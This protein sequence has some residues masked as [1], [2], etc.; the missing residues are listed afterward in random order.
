MKNQSNTV[1]GTESLMEHKQ[2]IMDETVPQSLNTQEQRRSERV[3]NQPERYVFLISP[4]VDVNLIEEDEPDT[5]E[6]AIQDIDS[7]LWREAMKFEMDSMYTNQVWTL[8]DAP[9]GVKL[10]RCNWVFKKKTNMDGNVQMYK[11][12]LVAKR[13]R[14]QHCVDYNEIFYL[15]SQ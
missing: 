15:L 6:E 12:R 1:Q 4:H 8:V 7:A 14:Y 11:D 5:Y 2:F 9:E 13:Y 3:R 10:I